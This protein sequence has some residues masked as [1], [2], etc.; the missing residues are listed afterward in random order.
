MPR[1]IDHDERRRQIVAAARQLMEEG[2]L[3]AATM[4][5][6]ASEA[7]FANGALKHYFDGKDAVILATFENVFAEMTE[8]AR[9]SDEVADPVEQLRAF[10]YA[11]FPL[12]ERGIASARVLF[13]L[14]EYSQTNAVLLERYLQQLR[15]WERELAERLIAVHGETPGDDLRAIVDEA[16]TMSIGANVVSVLLPE[17]VVIARYTRYVDDFVADFAVAPQGR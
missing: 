12:D 5:A 6:I 11:A 15:I 1:V 17:D 3:T 4:R 9:P 10:M 14:W 8:R 7:G 2:G 13:A 16:V